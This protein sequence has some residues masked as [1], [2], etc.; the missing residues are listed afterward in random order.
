MDELL[1]KHIKLLDE[2]AEIQQSLSEYWRAAFIQLGRARYTGI[3]IEVDSYKSQDAFLTTDELSDAMTK[4]SLRNPILDVQR[5]PSMQL[6]A[7]QTCFKE[8]VQKEIELGTIFASLQELE[9][10]IRAKVKKEDSTE[11]DHGVNKARTMAI[12]QDD[13]EVVDDVEKVA[14]PEPSVS[15]PAEPA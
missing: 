10:D 3:K 11:S 1:L 2:Y 7:T 15:S 8:A 9:R 13:A 12:R 5:L 6:K 4:L 14:V